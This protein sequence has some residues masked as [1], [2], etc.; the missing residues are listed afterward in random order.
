MRLATRLAGV[1]LEDA[2]GA[3][4]R[5]GDLWNKQPRSLLR[6]RYVSEF[7]AALARIATRGRNT[8][9]LQHAAGFLK[10]RLDTP[11]RTEL[12]ELIHDDR[13][14]LVPLVVPITLLRH[15]TRTHGVAYLTGQ[16]FLEP[17]PRERMLRNHI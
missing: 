12:A 7:M 16:S 8:N 13:R 10:D 2:D 17:H 14:G 1:Q 9:V 3:R 15:P 11:A 6:Q 4:R 5:L